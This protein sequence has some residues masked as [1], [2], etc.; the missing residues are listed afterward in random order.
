ILEVPVIVGGVF[1]LTNNVGRT[2]TREE[3]VVFISIRAQRRQDRWRYLGL[4]SWEES[5]VAQVVWCLV[6]VVTQEALHV[7]GP[8]Q[9][10][11]DGLGVLSLVLIEIVHELNGICLV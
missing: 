11:V 6:G 2:R 3:G 8:A 9:V 5:F 4:I 1:S 10:I 7:F